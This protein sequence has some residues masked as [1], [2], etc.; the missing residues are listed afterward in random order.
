MLLVASYLF[1]NNFNHCTNWFVK[2]PSPPHTNL[3][4]YET[5]ALPAS[6]SSSASIS[7]SLYVC[8]TL[9][10]TG[11]HSMVCISTPGDWLI[12]SQH[13]WMMVIVLRCTAITSCPNNRAADADAAAALAPRPCEPRCRCVV[14][15]WN[16]TKMYTICVAG[17]EDLLRRHTKCC[18]KCKYTAQLGTVST[19]QSVG[20][21]SVCRSVHKPV[22]P[23][24]PAGAPRRNG[25][26]QIGRVPIYV[27]GTGMH[28][29]FECFSSAPLPTC[30]SS[31]L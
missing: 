15:N 5:V 12:H 4:V 30:C 29:N 11:R 31:F 23:S 24:S 6:L 22:R 7:G 14:E 18:T 25:T 20:G 27:Y 28:F 10:L 19:Q 13:H 8:L 2:P 16:P 9:T 26:S 21:R 17:R 1:A 3:A